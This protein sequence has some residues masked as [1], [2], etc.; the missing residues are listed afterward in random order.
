MPAIPVGSVIIADYDVTP[1]GNVFKYSFILTAGNAG[2]VDEDDK[3]LFS[4]FLRIPD[5]KMV[6]VFIPVI[7]R[8]V[9]F[10]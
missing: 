5:D 4:R 1:A 7:V 6:F 8:R 10:L 2:T 9:K 3:R